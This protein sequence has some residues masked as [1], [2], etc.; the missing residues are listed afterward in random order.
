MWVDIRNR[1]CQNNDAHIFRLQAELVA[2]TQGPTESLI[3]YYGRLTKL[4][5]DI[6]EADP[7]P[8]CTCNPCTCSLVSIL[9]TRRD[10]KRVRDFLMGLDER[11]DNIRS[12]LLGISPSPTLDFVYNRLLQEEGM[13]NYSAHK[14]DQKPD[15]MAFATRTTTNTRTIGGGGDSSRTTDPTRPYCIACRRSGYLY[16]VCYRVTGEFPEWWGDRPRDR[17]YI[18]ETDMSRT[19]VPDI[20]GRANYDRKKKGQNAVP[21]AHLVTTQ[22]VPS[23]GVAGSGNTAQA[24][25]LAAST[26]SVPVVPSTGKSTQVDQIDFNALTPAQ[27]EEV[28]KIWQARQPGP[29]STARLSGPFFEDDDWCG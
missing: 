27:L 2:C 13:R 26:H 5:D 14:I 7:I 15:T 17:I 6:Q 4:W 21:R 9:D 29:S 28:H 20:Q 22:Q 23:N 3:T 1:F 12:Q 25:Y 11:Y 10:K 24:S 19:V 16:P 8:S 18:N